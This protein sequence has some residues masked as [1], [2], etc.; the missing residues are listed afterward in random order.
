MTAQATYMTV[1]EGDVTVAHNYVGAYEL[2]EISEHG[3]KVHRPVF[4]VHGSG[5]NCGMSGPTTTAP[6]A[7][8]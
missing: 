5:S 8:C 2:L 4:S 1:R 7:V 6:R 3:P